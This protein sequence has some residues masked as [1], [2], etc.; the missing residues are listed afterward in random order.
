[1]VEEGKVTMAGDTLA[2]EYPL[3]QESEAALN[4]V[5]LFDSLASANVYVVKPEAQANPVP[6][7][8]VKLAHG[9]IYANEKVMN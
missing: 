9:A 1:M 5:K 8:G 2:I 4:P 3:M 6:S 7:A